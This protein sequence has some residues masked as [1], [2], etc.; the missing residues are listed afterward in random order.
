M[1]SQKYLHDVHAYN[2]RMT[3]VQAAFLYEQLN[4]VENILDNKNKI[5]KNYE[6]LLEN[7]IK[8]KKI[9]LFKKEE[10]TENANWIFAIRIINNKKSID[11]TNEFFKINNI[12]VRPFF[13]PIN[14][15]KH[16][17]EIENKDEV[18]EILNKEILM[19]PSSPNITIDEQSKVVKII[20]K[21]INKFVN[22][23]N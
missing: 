21:F 12:D 17:N 13:Y 7:L 11:E 16:L 8:N 9:A 5:F 14:K 2:Y 20:E 15:H 23:F 1:S 4:D 3:N 19:I 10:N 22:K 6:L 18:S